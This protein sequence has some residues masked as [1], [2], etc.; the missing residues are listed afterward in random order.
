MA[1]RGWIGVQPSYRLSPLATFPEHLIDVKRAIA[2]VREHAD[3]L[4]ADPDFVVVSGGSAG[5]HLAALT[6]LTG[7]RRDLQPGFEDAD[8]SVQACVPFYGVYDPG[9]RLGH[10]SPDMTEFLTRVVVK[11]DP[12]ERP[13]RWA[14]ASPLE[15]IGPGAPPFLVVHGERDS[16][17][18]PQEAGA[19]TANVKEATSSPVGFVGLPGAQHAFD[20]FPSIRTAY[21]I[22]GVARFLATLHAATQTSGVV[23]A[24]EE[25]P[26]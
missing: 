21:T 17:T 15:Q 8:A 13:D 19:F 22:R 23:A 7:G 3:E 9:N 25:D 12:D 26:R 24:E 2:W 18:S 14:T 4:G 5:G 11:A 20:V 6:A 1:S 10:Q 16:L